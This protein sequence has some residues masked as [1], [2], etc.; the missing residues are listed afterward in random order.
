MK[1]ISAK[2]V[3]AFVQQGKP[4]SKLFC[5]GGLFLNITE[6]GTPIS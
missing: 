6:A 2:A 1:T 4:K 3:Q 5:G